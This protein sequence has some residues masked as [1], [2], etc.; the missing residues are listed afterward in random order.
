MAKYSKP[1]S[2]EDG[3]VVKGQDGL[4]TSLISSERNNRANRWTR[5]EALDVAQA[6]N[7]NNPDRATL[8]KVYRGLKREG[9]ENGLG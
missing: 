1:E 3:G 7:E 9:L 5:K 8:R 2:K 4:I 6:G